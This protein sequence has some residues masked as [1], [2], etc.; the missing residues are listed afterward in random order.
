MRDDSKERRIHRRR[1][2]S[3][4]PNLARPEE[5]TFAAQHMKQ[6][7]DDGVACT[8]ETWDDLLADR[9]VDF[10]PGEVVQSS[11]QCR[12]KYCHNIGYS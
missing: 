10:I 4:H 12:H 9:L 2:Q 3:V 11:M 8:R 5:V 6:T 1:R 7:I